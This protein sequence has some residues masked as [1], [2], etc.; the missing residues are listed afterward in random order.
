MQLHTSGAKVMICN[1][2]TDFIRQLYTGL[3]FVIHEVPARHKV[4]S[5]K[6]GKEKHTN[7]LIITT[8]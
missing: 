4:F 2:D 6:G 7:E 1:A 8:Y 3:P 5:R